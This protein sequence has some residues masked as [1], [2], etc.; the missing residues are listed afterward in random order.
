M[1]FSQ[2]L[3]VCKDLL[4]CSIIL[5]GSSTLPPLSFCVIFFH[6]PPLPNPLFRLFILSSFFCSSCDSSSLSYSSFY[7]SFLLSSSLF[8]PSPSFISLLLAF[9]LLLLTLFIPRKSKRLSNNLAS[10]IIGLAY[11]LNGI[12]MERAIQ[13]L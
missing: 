7:L 1:R 5:F 4:I 11:R 10:H 12:R 3:L 13:N 6:V 9:I 2:Y 8:L